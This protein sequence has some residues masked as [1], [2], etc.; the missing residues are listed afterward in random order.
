[1][2]L[3]TLEEKMWKLSR[4]RKAKNTRVTGSVP[5]LVVYDEWLNVPMNSASTHIQH[6][7]GGTSILLNF[8]TLHSV[9]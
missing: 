4:E 6:S 1:M 7:L 2:E 8:S 5:A 9:V 3:W